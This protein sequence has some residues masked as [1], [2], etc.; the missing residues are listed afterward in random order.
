MDSHNFRT[1]SPGEEYLIKKAGNPGQQA[2]GGK[3][4]SSFQKI[5]LLIHISD[6]CVEYTIFISLQVMR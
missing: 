5:L 2:G 4:K 1:N 3:Y 6:L